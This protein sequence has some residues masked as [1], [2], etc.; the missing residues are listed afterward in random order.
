MTKGVGNYLLGAAT[1]FSLLAAAASA[2][3]KWVQLAARPQPFENGDVLWSGVLIDITARKQ[4]EHRSQAAQT[5]LHNLINGIASPLFVKDAEHKLI[6]LNDA[7]CEFVGRSREA[8]L[9]RNRWL[10]RG[11]EPP[12]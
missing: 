11:P 3:T 5:F 4:A 2:Q 10:R 7:F 6:L 1:T 12:D 8:V 9:L